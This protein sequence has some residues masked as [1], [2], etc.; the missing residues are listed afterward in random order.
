MTVHSWALTDRGRVRPHN[1]NAFYHS[2]RRGVFLVANGVGGDE[3]A[4]AASALF[5]DQAKAWSEGF[6][7]LVEERGALGPS[8]GE[9][10]TLLTS[11]FQDASRSIF[12]RGEEDAAM[13]GL[14]TTAVIC[15]LVGRSAAIGHVGHNAAF[16]VRG[17]SARPL[18]R[19]HTVG[20]ELV[21]RG[22]LPTEQLPR[23]RYRNVLSRTIGGLP[24]AEVDLVWLDLLPG[25]AIVLGSKGFFDHVPPSELAPMVAEGPHTFCRRAMALANE[26]GGADNM[27]VLLARLATAEEEAALG[28]A[29]LAPAVPT[30]DTEAR[31]ALLRSLPLFAHL[32]EHE[33]LRVLRAIYCMRF[34]PGEAI[35]AE[36]SRGEEIYVLAEGTVLVEKAGVELTTLGPG[37]HF[38]D[39]SFIEGAPRSATVKALT[40]VTT[41]RLTRQ[42]F[43]DGIAREDPRLATKLLWGLC[44]HVSRRLRELSDDFVLVS[45]KAEQI[46]PG[47]SA[48]APPAATSE[49]DAT[50]EPAIAE[51]ASTRRQ[52]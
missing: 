21:E 35:V 15:A 38:G 27:T 51:A 34:E 42:D 5:L 48:A 4:Q 1:D 13:R 18:T 49:P 7:R 45:R 37:R 9:V 11:F 26:R 25:D 28:E 43:L 29:P 30:F 6:A 10:M 31:L 17:L 8:R 41:L 22:V 32:T 33:L 19:P 12:D 2:G 47:P 40:P 3:R 52:R 23:S 20:F 16:H 36:G 24:H 14:A 50:P 46:E 39:V 44:Q